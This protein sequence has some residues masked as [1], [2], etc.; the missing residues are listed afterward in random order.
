M[1]A[2]DCVQMDTIIEGEQCVY[3]G[4]PRRTGR[5]GVGAVVEEK[6]VGD[7]QERAFTC[8]ESVSGHHGCANEILLDSG[9]WP[10]RWECDEPNA[11][12]IPA[13]IYSRCPTNP[14]NVTLL[15]N[16]RDFL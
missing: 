9:Q 1:S 15:P 7:R 3:S 11:H 10:P 5:L 14:A 4:L 2:P 16:W 13:G 12:P 8:C 6:A